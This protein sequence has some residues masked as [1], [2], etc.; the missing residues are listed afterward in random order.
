M[1]RIIPLLIIAA[2]VAVAVFMSVKGKKPKRQR[3]ARTPPVVETAFVEE[4]NGTIALWVTGSVEAKYSTVLVPQVSGLIQWVNKRFLTGSFFKKGDIL[5]RID[6]TDYKYE[7]SKAK[8]DLAQ[9]QLDLEK[10]EARAL[11]AQKEWQMQKDWKTAP[12]PLPLAFYGPQ[13]EN[14]QKQVEAAKARVKKAETDLERTVIKAPFDCY[15]E[16]EKA[17]PGRFVGPSTELAKIV[18]SKRAEVVLPV[19]E[20]YLSWL[21]VKKSPD[22]K[23]SKVEIC[24]PGTGSRI[25]S[26]I[27]RVAP[28]VDPKTRLVSTFAPI[29]DPFCLNTTKKC[30]P[31][32]IGTFVEAV[33][34]AKAP[35]NTVT[36]PG[37]AL[38]E[39]NRVFVMEK[40][41]TVRKVTVEVLYSNRDKAWVIGKLKPGQRVITT[42]LKWA[43]DGMKVIPV[44]K[45]QERNPGVVR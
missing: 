16:W 9:A 23:G 8:A 37:S 18:F 5:V 30:T 31:I 26:E 17:E 15:V 25:T 38:K 41:Y 22:A 12:K 7:L 42:P 44:E 36:I 6:Q 4:S 10:I 21:Q 40:D 13:R 32:A 33:I 39:H 3:P 34:H 11:V 2:S 45:E 1:K 24:I 20:E 14:A 29:E 19:E 43:M 27:Y 35:Q 28:F